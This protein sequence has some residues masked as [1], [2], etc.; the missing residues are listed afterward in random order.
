[1]SARRIEPVTLMGPAGA[2]EAQWMH[3]RAPRPGAA[4]LCHPH[5][6][7]GGTLHTKAL[8]HAARALADAGLPVLRFNFRGV[9][10]SAGAHDYGAG[11]RDDAR[12][13][14]AAVLARHPGE[15][16]L[17]GGFSFG[18]WVGCDVGQESQATRAL[19]AIG[20]PLAL[21]D[22]TFVRGDRPLLCIVGDRDAFCSVGALRAFTSALGDRA[23]MV[24]LRGAEHLLT[25]HLQELGRAVAD[26]ARR[27]LG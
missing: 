22:F 20:P 7:H 19:L 17:V 23:E 6:L 12:T 25:T 1:L 24:V 14:L 8:Y 21:Y 13:A 3:P 16:L 26:F 11:E 10:R 2:L 27:T 5:P 4:L 15:P 9:G 18:S